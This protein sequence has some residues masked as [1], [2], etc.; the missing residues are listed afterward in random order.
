MKLGSGLWKV[1]QVASTPAPPTRVPVEP[2]SIDPDPSKTPNVP[3][4]NTDDI[5]DAALRNVTIDDVVSRLEMLVSVYNQREISRQLAILDIMMDRLGLAS[6]FPA[7]GEAMSKALE[8]N[9][10]IGNR[11]EE[12]LGKVKG[13]VGIP[14][15]NKW[16]QPNQERENP[17]TAG[18][19]Q[20]L[21]QQEDEE[22]K[23]KE[24]RKQKDFAK[25]QGG[26]QQVPVGQETAA[27]A[28][29][30]VGQAP[31]LQRPARVEKAPPIRT[32]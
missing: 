13:S 29:P 21:Q 17:Q 1:A 12:I 2:I 23:R 16:L 8:A 28:G 6:F 25:M 27:A 11:L 4:D 19:K 7:L 20:N 14:N 32:R 26:Q 5:I 24:M 3:D 18:I 15:A 30:P 22:E 9:Q 31:E 10:Y